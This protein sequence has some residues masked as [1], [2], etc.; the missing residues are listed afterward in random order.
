MW[1]VAS[2]IRY[3]SL[4]CPC[5]E[6]NSNKLLVTQL[7]CG[8]LRSFAVFFRSYVTLVVP[9]G[10][11]PVPCGPLRSLVVFIVT[12]VAQ[13]WKMTRVR[14][15]SI[16]TGSPLCRT[17]S[18]SNKFFNIHN[19]VYILS[20]FHEWI[21]QRVESA[22]Y[23]WRIPDDS[24]KYDSHYCANRLLNCANDL[25]LKLKFQTVLSNKTLIQ[26]TKSGC[27]QKFVQRQTYKV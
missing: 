5:G 22:Y 21:Y 12:L 3:M 25:M 10:V 26:S 1:W 20:A 6:A 27:K 19:A 11:F 16:I 23:P 8:A 9:C 14:L 7:P 13:S 24:R 2:L 4:I 18:I 15:W 17:L